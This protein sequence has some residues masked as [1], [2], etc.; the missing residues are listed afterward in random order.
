MDHNAFY[1]YGTETP[2]SSFSDWVG[3]PGSPTT[4]NQALIGLEDPPAT[5]SSFDKDID[6]ALGHPYDAMAPLDFVCQFDP[7]IDWQSVFNTTMPSPPALTDDSSSTADTTNQPLS[8]VSDSTLVNSPFASFLPDFKL[9]PAGDALVDQPVAS[10]PSPFDDFGFTFRCEGAAAVPPS[11]L[12]L[13]LLQQDFYYNGYDYCQGQYWPGQQPSQH[14]VGAAGAVVPGLATGVEVNANESAFIAMGP[15][16][17]PPLP[18]HSP[19]PQ[20]VTLANE[21]ARSTRTT[22]K[23]RS[24]VDSDADSDYSAGESNNGDDAPPKRTR[25]QDTTKRFTCPYPD[26]DS[27]HARTHNLKVHIDTVHLGKRSHCCKEPGCSRAFSR[28]HDL[29]RHHQSAHTTLGSP[30]NVNNVNGA[31]NGAKGQKVV[32]KVEYD[33]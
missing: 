24:H 21:V 31:S 17:F 10:S 15:T 27:A 8:P 7:L 16:S 9:P 20:Q 32:K 3:V 18:V 13:A 22:R 30:R 5:V 19:E 14:E 2:S 26:C 23:K 6:D 1:T 11:H 12:S 25:R 28:K 33:A 29:T 4:S